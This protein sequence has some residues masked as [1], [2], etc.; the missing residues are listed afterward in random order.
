MFSGSWEKVSTDTKEMLSRSLE[1]MFTD[2]WRSFLKIP[3]IN[4]YTFQETFS[5]DTKRGSFLTH[6]RNSKLQSKI[7]LYA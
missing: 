6:E 4:L 1:K 5:P 2:S 7:S 3:A